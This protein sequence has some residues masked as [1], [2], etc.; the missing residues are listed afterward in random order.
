MNNVNYTPP[1]NPKTSEGELRQVGFELEFS[2]IS[3]AQTRKV[4]E[5]FGA[6]SVKDSAVEAKFEH[7]LGSFNLELDAALIKNIAQEQGFKE[8]DSTWFDLLTQAASV[9]VPVEIVC[10]PIPFDQLGE[11]DPLL[12]AL[13][14]AGAQGTTES[15]LAAYG[16]HINT[17]A[18]N[19]APQTLYRYLLA[20]CLAQWWLVEAHEVDLTRRL[21]PFVD[22]FPESYLL[23]LIN[24]GEASNIQTLIDEYIEYNPTRNRALDMLPLFSWIDEDRVRGQ[25]DSELIKKRPTFHYR[26]PNCHIERAAWSL[27]DE[28]DRWLQVEK[29][30]SAPEL[31][32]QLG[33][34]YVENHK[35]LLGVN[36][37]Q[38]VS[39]IQ[40][41]LND[42]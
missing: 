7:P 21:S 40:T 26:L 23:H 9:V 10:P 28:W 22:L 27:R 38:W 16:V 35:F 11:L 29:L 4:L 12:L 31:L 30:A 8:G 33:K 39:K 2:G 24:Q 34:D 1:P 42:L 25:L 36:R 20:F 41:C 18:P 6:T 19:L 37:K 14:K 3:I 15:A 5:E 17:E 13:R 32:I